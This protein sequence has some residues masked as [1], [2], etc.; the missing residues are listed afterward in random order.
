M[1]AGAA[2]HLNPNDPWTNECIVSLSGDDDSSGDSDSAS[3]LEKKP[4]GVHPSGRRKCLQ[5]SSLSPNYPPKKLDYD[6]AADSVAWSHDSD[7]FRPLTQEEKNVQSQQT[8]QSQ[9]HVPDRDSAVGQFKCAFCDAVFQ[10]KADCQDH[11]EV[12][13]LNPAPKDENR[14]DVYVQRLTKSLLHK[15]KS[16]Q[17]SEGHFKRDVMQVIVICL[18]WW[19][20]LLLPELPVP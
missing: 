3:E 19:R 8:S 17:G 20:S 4:W 16:R 9:M 13:H 15:L 14:C 5:F 6:D 18:V 11:Q 2:K 7:V 1:C 12:C 10:E